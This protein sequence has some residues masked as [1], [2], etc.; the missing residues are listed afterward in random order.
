MESLYFDVQAMGAGASMTEE[1]VVKMIVR[2]VMGV[3]TAVW[4]I[5]EFIDFLK[6]RRSFKEFTLV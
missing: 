5:A 4:S 2:A 1:Y 6:T 3:C